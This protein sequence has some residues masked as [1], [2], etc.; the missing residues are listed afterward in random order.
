[1]E[2]GRT[3]QRRKPSATRFAI[4]VATALVSL[5][6]PGVAPSAAA[7]ISVGCGDVPE[8][9]DAMETATYGDTIRLASGCTYVLTED[10]APDDGLPVVSVQLTLEGR[11]S[12]IT[13]SSAR[14][15]PEFR[16]LH[17]GPRGNLSLEDVTLTNG[18]LANTF[19]KDGGGILNEGTLVAELVTVSANTAFQGGGINSD[20]S[21]TMTDSVVSDNVGTDHGGGV[22]AF[23]PATF[24]DTAVIGNTGWILGG[25]IV[26]GGPTT[27]VRTT[28]SGNHASSGGGVIAYWG[29]ESPLLVTDSLIAANSAG[30]AAGILS[31]GSTVTSTRSTISAN[32]ASGDCGG[33]RTSGTIWLVDT[34]VV[35]NEAGGEGGGVCAGGSTILSNST[36][37]GNRAFAGAGLRLAGGSFLYRSTLTGNVADQE[38][39]AI[40]NSGF[41]TILES[42][43]SANT[44]ASGGRVKNG[45][46]LIADR[47]T[48]TANSAV[49]GGGIYNRSLATVVNSTVWANSAT[50]GGGILTTEGLRVLSS[51]IGANTATGQYEGGGVHVL[52]T[53]SA[54][55]RNSIVAG[56]SG[57]SPNVAGSV[58]SL[59]H[60]VV[61][62]TTGSAGWVG[63]DSVSVANPGLAAGPAANGGPTETVAL[64]AGSPAV[65]QVPVASCVDANGAQLTFDQRLVA[66][67]WA[68]ACDAGAF[69]RVYRLVTTPGAGDNRSPAP[70]NEDEDLARSSAR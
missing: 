18:R 45:G 1:M 9:I 14:G 47:S 31:Y 6:G 64:L 7:T 55:I 12:T 54:E 49:F 16:I 11:G 36:V 51:T 67:P 26:G 68:T 65:N 15:T 4:G 28:V 27:L 58:T 66:R 40:F 19:G 5:L 23:G 20:G 56:N 3:R 70:I 52:G 44:G 60:N 57:G 21:L 29:A 10:Y 69:E 48:I 37:S 30:L 63:S 59:G 35:D 62:S 38:G 53:A 32:D 25:G 22:Y 17:I 2:A 34:A 39:G 13:R 61:G 24:A 42:T 33:V 50:I 43:L 46:S 41:L 8:L